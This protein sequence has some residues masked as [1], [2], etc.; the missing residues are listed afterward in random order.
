MSLRRRANS[1][2]LQVRTNVL[3]VISGEGTFAG[4]QLLVANGLPAAAATLRCALRSS[5]SS[6]VGV[7]ERGM[8]IN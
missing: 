1:K 7:D 5:G 3:T 8:E 2:D 4:S 6:R